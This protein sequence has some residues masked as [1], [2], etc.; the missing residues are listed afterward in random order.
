M[1]KSITFPLKIPDGKIKRQFIQEEHTEREHFLS[2]RKKLEN[3]SLDDCSF[4]KIRNSGKGK[5]II[6]CYHKPTQSN[7][8]AKIMTEETLLEFEKEFYI[9]TNI[10][11]NNYI[12]YIFHKKRIQIK[13]LIEMNI[14]NEITNLLKQQK[15][16]TKIIGILFYQNFEL[17]LREYLT[18]YRT[19]LSILHYH[20]IILSI[21]LGLLHLENHLVSYE[22]LNLDDILVDKKG[23]VFLSDFKSSNRLNYRFA[24]KNTH[25]T[26]EKKQKSIEQSVKIDYSRSKLNYEFGILIYEILFNINKKLPQHTFSS[27]IDTE[28]ISA[29]NNKFKWYLPIITSLLSQNVMD[30][31]SIF[32]VTQILQLISPS[33]L[34]LFYFREFDKISIVESS[35]FFPSYDIKKYLLSNKIGFDYFMNL[36]S[37]GNVDFQYKLGVYLL[38]F[39][40]SDSFIY[41]NLALHQDHFG[42]QFYIANCYYKTIICYNNYSFIQNKNN[43]LAFK[44]FSLSANQGYSDAQFHCGF[45]YLH[46]IGIKKN[47]SEGI[48]LIIQAANQGNT[49]AL[50]YLGYCYEKGNEFGVK[51]NKEKSLYYL[52][53]ASKLGNPMD[54]IYLASLYENLGDIKTAFEFYLLASDC[55]DPE[56]Q[57]ILG[58]RYLS[59]DGVDKDINEGIRLIKLSVDQNFIP[60]IFD[61][62]LC[63]ANGN[64]GVEKN[65]NEA[66]QLY[67]LLID[68]GNAKAQY[69]L[70]CHYHN[71]D[72]I[73]KNLNEAIRLYKLA[74]NQNFAPAIFN[75]G[76][77]YESGDGVQQDL[78]E[79]IKL[80][81]LA[82]DYD[83]PRAQYTLACHYEEGEYVTKDLNEAVRLYTL[84]SDSGFAPAQYNLASCYYSGNGVEKNIEKAIQLFTLASDNG[85]AKAQ[86]NLASC[87]EMGQ[88]VQKNLHEAFR[89]YTLAANQGFVR[90]QYIL[91]NF[92]FKGNEVVSQ[93][94]DKAME[95]YMSAAKQGFAPAQYKLALNLLSDDDN[96]G[97]SDAVV[98]L[99]KMASS[100]EYAPAQQLLEKIKKLCND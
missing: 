38:N 85:F 42:A 41:F 97:N 6:E 27:N 71:G 37:N 24:T 55:G 28:E 88:V 46:G 65:A 86:F 87:F 99:L 4:G 77:C 81:S 33:P 30:R 80:Y 76:C 78:N 93:D 68:K 36:A 34:D 21:A 90:A 47:Q 5:I 56:T 43:N 83:L 20:E 53:L 49:N 22:N 50:W 19:Q 23:K 13:T 69:D 59:G 17:T 16:K 73:E 66:I 7:F 29:E 8:L 12:E 91:A 15:D 26:N 58:L 32:D 94:I 62:A 54:Y 14:N 89:L 2:L 74:V 95:L 40:P 10:P 82:A 100:Q 98:T 63:Y 92:Y 25:E 39:L 44:Y 67:N 79:A 45:F 84:S 31:I 52:Q 70:A 75:L 48:R 9:L 57:Y 18:K 11:P 35:E 72:I 60:A 3:L 1:P 61:L 96:D 64:F 51:K